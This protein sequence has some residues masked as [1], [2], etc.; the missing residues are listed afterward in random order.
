MVLSIEENISK[1]LTSEYADNIG[2]IGIFLQRRRRDLKSLILKE[3]CGFESRPR[4]YKNT[5]QS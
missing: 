5:S 1:A 4:D 2:T 3:M